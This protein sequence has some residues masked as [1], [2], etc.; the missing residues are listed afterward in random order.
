MDTLPNVQ[1]NL[2]TSA[3]LLLHSTDLTRL[4]FGTRYIIFYLK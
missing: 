1:Q 4:T 2:L 3:F